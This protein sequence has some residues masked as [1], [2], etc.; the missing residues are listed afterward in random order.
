M[1]ESC[2]ELSIGRD[3]AFHDG[4]AELALPI[5]WLSIGEVCKYAGGGHWRVAP[6]DVRREF[7]ESDGRGL[8][9]GIDARE[10]DLDPQR[11][12]F[13][14][15]GVF[16]G[17]DGRA[18]ASLALGAGFFEPGE[19]DGGGGEKEGKDGFHSSDAGG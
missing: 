5:A 14:G 19:G 4:T 18:V 15:E 7:G 2:G 17:F 10:C 9:L 13:E 6:G 1:I 12:L 8:G 3:P 11:V 16:C